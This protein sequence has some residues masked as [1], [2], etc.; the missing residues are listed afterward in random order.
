MNGATVYFSQNPVI[1]KLLLLFLCQPTDVVSLAIQS[2]S[3]IVA[4]RI[5][6][7]HKQNS[8]APSPFPS[9]REPLAPIL[10]LVKDERPYL[11]KYTLNL[12]QKASLFARF[13]PDWT[14]I[15]KSFSLYRKESPAHTN[16]VGN[17]LAQ[18]I[19]LK[20]KF[21]LLLWLG[22]A[23]APTGPGKK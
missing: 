14:T 11:R 22:K 18:S 16:C 8:H 19:S 10:P 15:K 23:P 6:I 12:V 1:P 7:A 3:H 9:I 20:S 4:C 2:G 17:S 21:S 13:L 5:V